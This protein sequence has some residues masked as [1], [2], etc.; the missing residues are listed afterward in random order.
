MILLTNQKSSCKILSNER[1]PPTFFFGTCYRITGPLTNSLYVLSM[2][3][4]INNQIIYTIIFR[5]P[6]CSMYVAS[7]SNLIFVY[8]RLSQSKFNNTEGLPGDRYRLV[9][10]PTPLFRNKI[11]FIPGLFLGS[12]K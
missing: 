3:I 7:T 12:H 9:L 6:L 4:Y 5:E 10:L 1:I 8:H 11:L 2:F